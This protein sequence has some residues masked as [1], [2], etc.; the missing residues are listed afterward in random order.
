MSDKL[1]TVEK[2]EIFF[3]LST[4]ISPCPECFLN[5]FNMMERLL[6]VLISL[7]QTN[8]LAFGM[9]LTY[10]SP[11]GRLPELNLQLS[12]PF[13]W[14]QTKGLSCRQT[15]NPFHSYHR[16]PL[17]TIRFSYYK[18]LCFILTLSILKYQTTSTL[19]TFL[20]VFSVH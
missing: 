8:A 1:Q 12:E 5:N 10:F 16:Y 11:K 7:E 17:C 13:H 2:E 3:K 15:K 4:W 6:A 14:R 9:A 19:R 18:L 20:C